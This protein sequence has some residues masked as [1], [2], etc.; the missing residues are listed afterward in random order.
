M[1][2]SVAQ[3]IGQTNHTAGPSPLHPVLT[4]TVLPRL[5]EVKQSGSSAWP[6]SKRKHQAQTYPQGTGILT[7]FPFGCYKLCAVLGPT[8][9]R[10]TTRCRGNLAHTAERIFTF[11]RCYFPQD[12]HLWSVHRTSRTGFCPTTTPPY[13]HSRLTRVL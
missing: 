12:S 8:D 13:Q 1:P 5:Q 7:S 10:S 4:I 3:R 6:I 11:L 9:P 2:F